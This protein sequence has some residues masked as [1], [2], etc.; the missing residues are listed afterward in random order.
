M[1]ANRI[2]YQDMMNPLF[3]HPSDN[4]SSIQVDKLEGSSD[5]RAWRRLMETNLSSK[6]KLGFLTGTVPIPTDDPLK[7]KC[8]KLAIR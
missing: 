7:L 3:L 4:T 1:A 6:R 2:T 5:Y 8:G